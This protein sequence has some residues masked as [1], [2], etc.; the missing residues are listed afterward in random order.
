MDY[1]NSCENQNGVS[2]THI[3]DHILA[4][5]RAKDQMVDAGV[6][7]LVENMSDH[8]PIYAIIKTEHI[9]DNESFGLDASFWKKNTENS[10]KK[11]KTRIIMMRSQPK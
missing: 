6:L 8:Q 5:T 4:L 7:H 2:S 11:F 10:R 1:T 3:L 9:T